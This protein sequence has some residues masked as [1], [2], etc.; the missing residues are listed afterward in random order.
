MLL[1]A[2]EKT[3]LKPFFHLLGEVGDVRTLT[4][5]NEILVAEIYHFF[6]SSN[7]LTSFYLLESGFLTHEDMVSPKGR[8]REAGGIAAGD[9]EQW[10]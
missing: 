6:R 8:W 7:D 9:N 4:R 5:K 3:A 1:A 10:N 2:N